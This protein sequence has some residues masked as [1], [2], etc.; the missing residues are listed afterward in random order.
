MKAV[1]LIVA[2]TALAGV[3][4]LFFLGSPLIVTGATDE[5]T[6][7]E[8]GVQSAVTGST[9]RV[10]RADAR[11]GRARKRVREA[12]PPDDDDM[13]AADRKLYDAVQE[14]WDAE[15]VAAV[16]KA[17][18]EAYKSENVEVRQQ[19]VDALAWFGEKTLA[20][21]TPMMVDADADVAESARDAWE[22]AL[23]DIESAADRL[24]I[25]RMALKVVSDAETLEMVGSQFSDAASE[26]IDEEEDEA[27]AQR[28]RVEVVQTLVDLIGDGLSSERAVQA[29]EIYESVTCNEWISAEEAERY[30]GDPDGYEPPEDGD[31]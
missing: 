10:M 12:V 16:R 18:T 9:I 3:A 11:S 31:G 8:G 17:A 27:K 23:V 13:T 25:T 24:H 22:S 28:Y 2:F 20:E 29:K 7:P 14:A 19:A 5:A 30:L 1:L 26:L 21:L 6:V 15:D 4:W